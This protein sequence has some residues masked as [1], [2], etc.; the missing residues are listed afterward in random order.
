MKNLSKSII[1]GII[2][3]L[4]ILV[5][6]ISLILYF[7][8]QINNQKSVLFES[9]YTNFAWGY[10]NYGYI[11]YSDGTIEEYDNSDEK[12][13]TDLKKDKITKEELNQLKTLAN[14]V[15][16]K[17]EEDNSG[18]PPMNDGGTS[19]KSIYNARLSKFVILSKSGD[20]LGGNSTETSK[21]ILEL[22]EKLYNKYL[23]E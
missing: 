17:Y 12:R 22:T 4:L 11:I 23:N 7:N 16:D 20:S 3:L 18:F 19:E 6:I 8:N 2:I 5:S 14:K 9:S 21:E 10:A 13:I 1:L 15:E